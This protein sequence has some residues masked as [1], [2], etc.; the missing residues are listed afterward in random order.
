M[1]DVLILVLIIIVLYIICR[2][3]INVSGGCI[4]I[5]ER[6]FCGGG[7][8]QI[9]LKNSP[10]PAT[11]EQKLIKQTMQFNFNIQQSQLDA[12]SQLKD[13]PAK[14]WEYCAIRNISPEVAIHRLNLSNHAVLR[15]DPKLKFVLET[16][17]RSKIFEDSV[18]AWLDGLHVEYKTENQLKA[19]GSVLTPDFYIN[20]SNL[21]VGDVKINWVDAKNYPLYTFP[22]HYQAKLEKM[23]AKYNAAFGPGLIVFNGVLINPKASK[24][25]YIR[26]NTVFIT[27]YKN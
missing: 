7:H 17:K 12:L 6:R 2:A 13:N 11:D 20:D 22:R 5:D 26:D 15:T 1:V 25:S 21:Y 4:K 9:N 10:S 19:E 18:G 3:K 27:D 23:C 16:S 8:I 14:F 24:V